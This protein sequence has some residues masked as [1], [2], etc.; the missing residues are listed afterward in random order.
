MKIRDL[1]DSF[2]NAINISNN[3]GIS[4]CPSMTVSSNSSLF[5][6]WQDKSLGNNEA[7]STKINL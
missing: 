6:V 4:E 3:A 1:G 2:S 7:L 5:V